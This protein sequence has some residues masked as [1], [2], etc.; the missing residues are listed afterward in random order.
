MSYYYK[1]NF[2][3]PEHI[4]S[5]IKEEMKSYFDTGAIDDLMFPTYLDKC[6]RKLGKATYKITETVLFIED[7][8]A[9]LPDNFYSVR[10]A[11]M[12]TEIPGYPYK[13]AN[14]FYS[15]AATSTTI[16]VSP[17][18]I[19][20]TPCVGSNCPPED[21]PDCMPELLQAVYKTNQEIA[22]FYTRN[23]LL[24]PG[25]ISVTKDCEFDYCS[26][27]TPTS[28]PWASSVDSFDIR[29]NKFVTNFRKGIVHLVFY[30]TESDEVGNQLIPDNYRIQEYIEAF[31]KY[32]LFETLVNQVNDET[33]N[34]LQ[35]KLIY[36]KQLCDEAYVIAEVEIKKQTPWEK[37]RRIKNLLNRFNMYEL[38]NK[39][40]RYRRRR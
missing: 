29:D 13:S 11:W 31:I 35:Q 12:C 32:K 21:C 22:R 33:F 3:S 27:D 28:T 26:M 7:F 39:N 20:G 18:T 15:Q 9:R 19:G 36:Y 5:I 6:L 14:S 17:V 2:K 23:Y 1:Y 16:Q 38:P 40:F 8:Q 10:E 25:N 30:S 34:Q 4:F 37:Q 24:K